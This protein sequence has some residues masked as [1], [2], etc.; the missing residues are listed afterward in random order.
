MRAS[1]WPISTA[2]ESS[3]PL[4]TAAVIGS[5]LVSAVLAIRTSLR[6][7]QVPGAVGARR[8]SG[9]DDGCRVE[10]ED[11]G[12][13]GEALVERQRGAVVEAGRQRL[14]RAV[15]PEVALAL[16]EERAVGRAARDGQLLERRPLADRAHARVHNL[17]RVAVRAPVLALVQAVELVERRL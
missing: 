11:D 1:L 13:A 8:P 4:T 14:Q 10:V 7:Q 12:G 3:A 5:T 16:T 9:R 17:D 2:M 6:E 15:D